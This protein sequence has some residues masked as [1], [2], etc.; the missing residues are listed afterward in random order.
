MTWVSGSDRI[1]PP[2]SCLSIIIRVISLNAIVTGPVHLMKGSI[3][4]SSQEKRNAKKRL[5]EQSMSA[6]AAKILKM[7]QERGNEDDEVT[8]SLV[9]ADLTW[10]RIA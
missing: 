7:E 2:N 10:V 8:L 5:F 1:V 9:H 6:T 4:S 3:A